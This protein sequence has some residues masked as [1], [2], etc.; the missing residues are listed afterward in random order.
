MN[1]HTA[2]EITEKE[3]CTHE[4][5]GLNDALQELD[6]ALQWRG[7]YKDKIKQAYPTP[8]KSTYTIVYT[9]EEVKEQ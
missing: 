4:I 6:K 5:D 2:I 7:I 8:A 3:L 1:K 9:K